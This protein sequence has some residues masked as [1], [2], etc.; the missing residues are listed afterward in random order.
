MIGDTLGEQVGV[1]VAHGGDFDVLRGQG[2]EGLD[3]IA[4]ATAEAYDG[5][6]NAVIG[7]AFIGGEDRR[8]EQAGGGLEERTA[9]L[10]GHSKSI[11]Q[12]LRGLR[13]GLLGG[14]ILLCI[15]EVLA[16]DGDEF[17][18]QC[19]HRQHGTGQRAQAACIAHR[20]R[21]ATALHT[22]HG[23]LDDG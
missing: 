10:C 12:E 7:A 22:S 4:A 5:D 8:G 18:V 13:S 6:T 17:V 1:D 16:V 14:L 15:F 9:K 20:N 19:L 11:V 23:C 3:V 21:H 2:L